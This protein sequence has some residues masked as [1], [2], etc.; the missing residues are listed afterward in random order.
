MSSGAGVFRT[1]DGGN[2][3]TAP[4][5]SVSGIAEAPA[6]DFL[7]TTGTTAYYNTAGT[8]NFIVSA[9]ATDGETGIQKVNFPALTGIT[10]GS[11]DDTSNPYSST[12]YSFSG[13][14]TQ[15]GAA[16]A[17]CYNGQGTTN[18][19]GFTVLLDTTNPSAFTLNDG[20]GADL[21]TIINSISLDA[22]WTVSTDAGSGLARYDY[23]L[24]DTTSASYTLGFTSNAASTTLNLST[25]SLVS[26][27]NYRFEVKAIDNVSNSYFVQSD[28]FLY[29]SEFSSV[30]SGPG[31]E[32]STAASLGD[33]D[34][35]GDLD[36]L[37]ANYAAI[38]R[39]YRNDGGNAFTSVWTSVETDAS[40]GSTWGDVDND[41][42]LD[43]VIA[44]GGGPNRVYLNNG[45]CSFALAWTAG[46]SEQTFNI[47]LGDYDADGDLDQLVGNNTGA[48]RVYR[49]DW[50]VSGSFTLA[51][52]SVESDNTKSVAWGDYDGD[53][54]LD[55]L[56]GNDTTT[57]NRVYRNDGGGVFTLVWSSTE[58]DNTLS[59]AWGDSDGDGDLDQLVGNLNQPNRVY[60]NDGASTFTLIWSSS[61]SDPTTGIAWGD[62]DGDGDLDQ[63]V[64]NSGGTNRVYRNDG[65]NTFTLAWTSVESEASEGLALGDTDGDGDMDY[66]KAGN[67]VANRVYVNNLNPANNA[68]ATPALTAEPDG[69]SGSVKLEWA[70]ASDAQTPAA[71]L[72]YN[73][74]V[75]TTPGGNEIVSAKIAAGPGNMGQA[76]SH[77]VTLSAG[78]SAVTYY[79]S[80]QAVDNTGFLSSAFAVE[81]N[82]FLDAT[83]PTAVGALT[84]SGSYQTSTTTVSA[85][86]SP[87]SDGESSVTSYEVSVGTTP[88]ATDAVASQS[89]G[90]VTGAGIAGTF[91]TGVTYYVNVAAINGAGLT[92]SISSTNGILVDATAPGAVG[93]LTDSGSFQTSTTTVSASWSAATDAESGVTDYVVSVGTTPGG[94]DA[95]ASQSVGLVTGVAIAGSYVGSTFYYVSVAAVNAAGLTG[96]AITTDGI[97]VETSAPGAV[98]ALTD[99]GSYQT[100]TS[101]IS[102]SWTAATDAESGI[103]FYEVSV[104]T[105]PGWSDFVASQSV[106][107]VTSAGIA[108]GYIQGQTY[109]LNVA[110]INGAGLTGS[111]N[112]TDGITVD[113]TPPAAVGAL[114]D[115]GSYQTSTTTVSASW[116]PASDGESSVTSYEVSVGTTP[117]ATDAVASQSVGLVTGAGIAGTFTTGV[118]YYVNV[119]AINGAGLTGSI[120]STNGILVDATAPAAVGALTDSGSFQ[121]GSTT[122]SASWTASTDAET[123]IVS[124][125]V[126]VGTSPG[127]TD[128]VASQSVGLSTSAAIVASYSDGVTY[129]VNVAAVNG[130]GLT[131]SISSTN[132]IMVDTVGPTAVGALTDSGSYQTSTTTLSASWAA[133]TDAQSGIA[134][135]EVSVG[136]SPGAT[137]AVASQS[138][139]LATAAAI[140]GSFTNGV[141]YYVNVVAVNNAGLTGSVSSTDGIMVDTTAP[142]AVGALTDSG[143]YT[144]GAT[145][146]SASWSP[147]S[148]G[149]SSVT[150]YEVSV[151][152]S[153]GATD[154]VASQ[155]VGL[156]TGVAIGPMFLLNGT[157]Y[158]INVAAINGAGLTSSIASTD[159]IMME[160]T[161][162]SAVSALTDSG[163]FQLS[164]TTV[165][166]SW[167]AATDAESG[168]TDYVVSVGTTP[169][170][171]D[172]VASQSVGLV[173]GVAIAGSYTGSVT[174]YVSVAAVNAAGLTGS[175]ITTD[176][177]TVETSAPGAVGALTD[178]GS[179]QTSTTTVSASWT[180]AT[181]AQSGIAS[182]E[183]S[184]GTSPGATD[185]V[186]SQSVG[187]ATAAAIAGSFTN[188]VTYYVNVAAVN[189]AGLTG[190]VSSTDGILVDT[191][192]PTAAGSLTDDGLYT[193]STTNL[194]VSWTVATDAE[195]GVVDYVVSVGTTPGATDTVADQ[196]VGLVTSTPIAGSYSTGVTYYI[197]VAAVNGA[198]LTGSVTSTDGILVDATAPSVV[199]VLT[200]SGSYQT[201]TTTVS[202]SWTAATDAQSG[203]ADYE[204]SVGTS[205]GLDDLVVSQSVGLAASVAFSGLNLLSG[206]TIYINVAAVNNA[207]LTGSLISTNGI[208]VDTTAPGVVGTLT[209]SGS[210]QTSTTTI[211]A[212]WAAATD[213]ESGVT[214]YV[215]SVGTSPGASDTVAPQSVGLLAS[216]AIAGAFTNGGA[217]YV[218]VAAV[219]GAGITGSAATTDGIIVD[220]TAPS[221]VGALTDSGSF[222]TSTTTLSA[223]WSVATDAE[224]GVASYE[225][226][227]GTSPGAT[228]TVASQSVGLLTEKG[229]A[230]TFTNGVTYYVNVLALNTAGSRGP[231][232]STNGITVDT[233]T[234]SAVSAL[235]DGAGADETYT[236][237]ASTLMA[238]WTAATGGASGI[239]GYSYSIGTTPGGSDMALTTSVGLNTSASASGLSLSDGV[240]YYV[241]VRAVNGLG[242]TGP[243]ATTNGVLRDASPPGASTAVNDGAGADIAF[244]TSL[245]SLSVNWSAATDAHSGVTGYF[246]SVGTTPGGT[247]VVA[248]TSVGLVTNRTF[249]GLSLT[250]GQTYY[251]NVQAQNGS[252][253]LG[254]TRSTNGVLVDAT[255]PSAVSGLTDGSAFTTS[256]TALSFSFSPATDAE[257][258]VTEYSYSIGTT[259]GGA[260]VAPFTSMGTATSLNVTGLSLTGGQTYFVTVRTLNAAGLVGATATTDGITVDTT[261]PVLTQVNDGAGADVDTWGLSGVV[262]AS[263]TTVT[264]AESGVTQLSASLGLSAGATD[265]AGWQ[266]VTGL[267]STTFTGLSLAAGQRFYVN[268][269]AQ[270]GAGL[271]NSSSS[272]GALVVLDAPT[273]VSNLSGP[274]AILSQ[275]QSLSATWTAAT[276]SMGIAAYSVSVGTAP[277]LSD[278]AP[279]QSVGLN[280]SVA[281]TG[282]SLPDGGTYYLNVRAEDTLGQAGAM[283]S[284]TGTLI[285]LSPPAAA[286]TTPAPGAAYSTSSVLFS[287]TVE[288]GA[289]L[290]ANYP[291]PVTVNGSVFS[292][293]L[294]LPEG[295]P[296]VQLT[297]I[298][299]ALNQTVLTRS[300]TVDVT[301][302]VPVMNVADDAARPLV[303]TV[304]AT[305]NQTLTQVKLGVQVQGDASSWQEIGSPLAPVGSALTSTPVSWDPADRVGDFELVLRATDALGN[306][307]TLTQSLVLRSTPTTTKSWPA[308]KWHLLAMPGKSVPSD[309][310]D[311]IAGKNINVLRYDPALPDTGVPS[312]RY[313]GE[314][315][316]AEGKGFW[317]YPYGQ[318]AVLSMTYHRGATNGPQRVRMATGWNQI[319]VPF[320]LPVNVAGLRYVDPATGESLDF[321]N[322]KLRGWLKS[323][324]WGFD[325]TQYVATLPGAALQP[326]TGYF[327]KVT[328]DLDLVFDPATTARLALPRLVRDPPPLFTLKAR[329]MP[330]SGVGY[331]QSSVELAV[332]PAGAPQRVLSR[333]SS[334]APP[335]PPRYVRVLAQEEKSPTLAE[336]AQLA[337]SAKTTATKG[338]TTWT[339]LVDSSEAA[340]VTMVFESFAPL[341]GDWEIHVKDETTG[342]L[343]SLTGYTFR[344]SGVA[345]DFR[346]FEVRVK[347][348][349]TESLALYRHTLSGAG[350]WSAV[351]F[352]VDAVPS[353]ASE[354]L[355]GVDLYQFHGGRLLRPDASE[356]EHATDIQAGLGYLLYLPEGRT[357]G[358]RGVVPSLPVAVPLEKGWNLLGNPADSTLAARDIL[359]R[360]K[361]QTLT[362][363]EARLLGLTDGVLYLLQN[364]AYES[365]DEV[366]AGAGFFIHFNGPAQSAEILLG[367][368]GAQ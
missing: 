135:Y 167:S 174:Y 359:I 87:A 179:Y 57:A 264:D 286:L 253:L 155:S 104:G 348:P 119:A 139:G 361:D 274:A 38:N 329:V 364:G 314:F 338:E 185:A 165:S 247:N 212:S 134:S 19:G 188:G 223:S 107:L 206:M 85:S 281:L 231:L 273:T 228:N 343:V 205:P 182:Y 335:P 265:L 357:L 356:S 315:T 368:Q 63:V 18:T 326:W 289:T 77:A 257:S 307:T 28:G 138:V 196:S 105:A 55:Q 34:G 113:T 24:Y 37:V 287:G 176:G 112:S 106:G 46:V 130:V 60:R 366:P 250:G 89:V 294:T 159:G 131:S 332:V 181:D 233:N 261:A 195:S 15:N 275:N 272:D 80:V 367:A 259:A 54:D 303:I 145:Y 186:A 339:L 101:T 47:S 144:T 171:F 152:T 202:A 133:A 296:V 209:D 76:L 50:N 237:S 14:S 295:A 241:S 300:V 95:V 365:T 341:S 190:S 172:A 220:A 92:G 266:D 306:T 193:T 27:H 157:T 248:S 320:E 192:A 129:Y 336:G 301:A 309:M 191:T 278:A 177:I 103:A 137:D 334:E 203:V 123:G 180:A 227:V 208:T 127:A 147:A 363:D 158:Y 61:E 311:L 283:A 118:T 312:A 5:C 327:Q 156:V 199:G 96:S 347:Q 99:S 66:L 333:L 91:T 110:A 148:D 102:A 116:S 13:G 351:A 245:S 114:T 224:S 262:S 263:W 277:G 49:N 258:S 126:S 200:D 269:R 325:T 342:E 313:T 255:A 170:G 243:V 3:V 125:E 284:T 293:A 75:G 279:W 187:L 32:G 236:S 317:L 226:S 344:A 292:A 354:Q 234:P 197:N 73:L 331:A 164:T 21:D 132:G 251:A 23:A 225:V 252:G 358:V 151:G 232:A 169:G 324:L 256:T 249:T 211:S 120:S 108:G 81:D 271:L 65:G 45:T 350:G 48:N 189:N 308:D 68:P 184:V 254:T 355:P 161:A 115:S 310:K 43:H 117:G 25:G 280:T 217:Y 210:Y 98:G 7:F 26:G 160:I 345:G 302:P 16:N 141:T 64:I 20:T 78:A 41:G 93:A 238:N 352:A 242:V 260:Q 82:F 74:R 282:L 305:D 142:S 111:I 67:S 121:T 149:E 163:S 122:I 244:S 246:V 31:P 86:W 90:L 298:D 6:S 214:D 330:I 56:V 94:F 240:T 36:Q 267:T 12:T 323:N 97:T 316:T 318:D 58:T 84:D 29:L 297:A 143:S 230:G 109:Y 219:N 340:D 52:T 178:S 62:Y 72:T 215:V 201:D 198:G 154:A 173:T 39:V 124:Y 35:D 166:A 8:G 213:T 276:S 9:T 150:G 229:I 128:T 353:R 328:R 83:P 349:A 222:Q 360:Q 194:N 70:A 218:N 268:L 168:V 319:G 40:Y 362:L 204:V 11:G 270:N 146:L 235:N 288:T 10:G 17:T 337:R 183:V 207:G 321:D 304:S 291:G 100:S 33:C 69:V 175:A 346:R 221:A 136:T 216:A 2:D 299:A 1:T 71:L 4:A 140:A 162:P 42:D 88:G 239:T 285:D 22:N 44:N 59:V 30:W 290:A 79:W 322:A 51:W 153:P 53:G